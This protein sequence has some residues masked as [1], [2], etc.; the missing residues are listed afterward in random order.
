[1]SVEKGL[2]IVYSG[3]SGSG[4]GTVREK[5]MQKGRFAFSVSATTRAP[6]AGEVDGVDYHYITREEFEKRIAAGDMLEYTV[7]NGNYYGT[8]L[9]EAL[10]VIEAG[11]DLLLE[12]EVEGAMN[13]KRLY[14]DAVLI[15]L[16]PPSFS[17]QEK[18]LRG[19]GTESEEVIRGRLERT[20]EEMKYLPRYDYLVYNEDGAI[21][22][23][24]DE[25]MAVIRCEKHA[26]K[27]HPD[28]HVKY[29]E[30]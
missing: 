20:R 17:E 18:R 1:M 19:R 30:N 27:R 24:A 21:E 22:E 29:F 15:M 12:I 14:P 28:A 5:L 11:E 2:L 7:Y 4:K 6:R 13:V 16:L 10:Q 3:P 25:I 23:C 26:L 8:P 9:R